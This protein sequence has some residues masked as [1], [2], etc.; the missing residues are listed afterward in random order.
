M[1]PRP[2]PGF[3]RP[4]DPLA[5]MRCSGDVR[6]P[7]AR[8]RGERHRT[9]FLAPLE[10]ANGL[11]QGLA[12]GEREL[13]PCR[14]AVG[15][16][17][18]KRTRHA[19]CQVLPAVRQIRT[20]HL[21]AQHAVVPQVQDVH[22]VQRGLALHAA[23]YHPR[24]IGPVQAARLEERARRARPG[25]WGSALRSTAGG[26]T[27][28]APRSQNL[29]PTGQLRVAPEFLPRPCL[30]GDMLR[31]FWWWRDARAVALSRGRER[32]TSTVRLDHTMVLSLS[33]YTSL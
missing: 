17:G 11:L 9:A 12:G 13:R 16:L 20:L 7:R 14:A 6:R 4:A 24:A 2:S 29:I 31:W 28:G 3:V 30:Q 1:N 19:H 25:R 33:E 8:G 23:R 27:S 18:G 15:R 10:A 32:P 21:P 5:Q 26:F 22:V